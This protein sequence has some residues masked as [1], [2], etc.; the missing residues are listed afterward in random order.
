V[1]VKVFGIKDEG[2]VNSLFVEFPRSLEKAL[3]SLRRDGRLS[4]VSCRNELPKNALHYTFSQLAIYCSKIT[5]SVICEQCVA[6]FQKAI[7]EVTSAARATEQ[8]R[9]ASQE[10]GPAI[11]GSGGGP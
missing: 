5:L 1:A 2:Q 3:V 8:A 9:S 11:A 6:P 10:A 7:S 4:C